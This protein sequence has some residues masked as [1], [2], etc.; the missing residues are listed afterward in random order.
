MKPF[1]ATSCV[2]RER[3]AVT[4]W[5][6]LKFSSLSLFPVLA[7]RTHVGSS[8]FLPRKR[9]LFPAGYVTDGRKS[10]FD[11]KPSVVAGFSV[12]FPHFCAVSSPDAD[13]SAVVVLPLE[14]LRKQ[15]VSR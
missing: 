10:Q 6:F 15:F 3:C 11:Y 9:L 13:Q 1:A 14:S 2:T 8:C 7:S 12:F 4:V 5:Q